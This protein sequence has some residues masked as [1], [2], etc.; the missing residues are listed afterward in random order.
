MNKEDRLSSTG[1]AVMGETMSDSCHE[2]GMRDT[3]FSAR[4][5][6]FALGLALLELSGLSR[7]DSVR[8]EERVVLSSQSDTE[9]TGGFQLD[10]GK[11]LS[12][13]GQGLRDAF[14]KIEERKPISRTA[15]AIVRFGYRVSPI[16]ILLGKPWDGF[17]WSFMPVS[18]WPQPVENLVLGQVSGVA[19]DSRGMTYVFHRGDH[20]ILCFDNDGKLLRYWGDGVIG[21]AHGLRIDKQGDVWVTDVGRHVVHQ[22]SPQGIL[23]RT[24]GTLD[25]PGTDTR[26]FDQPADVAFGPQGEILVADGYG[27]SRVM[28]FDSSGTFLKQWGSAGDQDGQFNLPHSIVVNAKNQVL[29]GDRENDRIQIFDLDGRLLQ[30]WKGFAPFGIAVATTGE[31]FVADGRAHAILRIGEQGD[32][33]ESWGTQGDAPGQFQLPHMLSIDQT[34]NLYVA[35][36]LGK[37]AQKLKRN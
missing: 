18:D 33:V 27:N 13:I 21:K 3:G 15:S 22:F 19:H 30:I 8:A 7:P 31:V 24:L 2:S 16:R 25:E 9:E 11:G 12:R 20:P 10:P 26:H 4:Y 5:C 17:E 14:M 28:K 32:V 37:R 6:C 35:E 36:V 1:L 29:V 23:K 34:G